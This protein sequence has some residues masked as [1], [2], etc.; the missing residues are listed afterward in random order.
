MRVWRITRCLSSAFIRVRTVE[1]INIVIV[2]YG[3][4]A[5]SKGVTAGWFHYGG[6]QG[7]EIYVEK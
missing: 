5:L 2:I 3:N 7:N 4:G 1:I 6:I